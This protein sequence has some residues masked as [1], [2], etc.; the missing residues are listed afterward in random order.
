MKEEVLHYVWQHQS[1]DRAGLQTV[2]QKPII[3]RSVGTLN[4]NAGPDFAQARLLI[5]DLEWCGSVEIHIRSSDWDRHGHQNDSAYNRVVLHVVWQHDQEVFRLDGTPIPTLELK[6][7]VDHS[8][9]LRSQSLLDSQ[10]PF[11]SCALQVSRVAE[12]TKISQ[13]E[14]VAAQ[15]LERKANEILNQLEAN[16]GNWE[17]T[18]YQWLLKGFG[19]KTNQEAMQQLALAL[20]L[21][22]VKKWYENQLQLQTVFLQQAGLSK[23]ASQNWITQPPE[24]T[25][26]RMSTSAWRYSRM[27]PANMPHV[28]IKQVTQL[29]GK[30]EANLSWLVQMLSV[31][32]Y[33]RKFSLLE[34]NVQPIGKGSI[35]VLLINTVV[36]LLSA[37]GMYYRDAQ[38]QQHA[39]ECLRQLPAEKNQI[40]KK[41]AQL[42]FPQE[43]A[44][45]SQGLIELHQH[46]CSK[47]QCLKCS[48]GS[49]VMKK[50][51][52]FV[53]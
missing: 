1:F 25:Q 52:L 42:G 33:L 3:I 51:H 26:N 13:I 9:L 32:E 21:R 12:I 28:R 8:V 4:S 11:I 53:S 14:R 23:Y 17:E 22:W 19:F 10:Q 43:S 24:L 36:P 45:D 15:R 35:A 48:I 50:H 49:E 40:T 2:Q 5:G 18:S 6:Q 31:D 37:Y 29:L 47:K 30:W 27:R 44:L 34:G 7:R 39:W 38:Y 16:G 46:F 41:Y 20:P